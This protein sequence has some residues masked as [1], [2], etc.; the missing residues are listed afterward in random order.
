MAVTMK[1][2]LPEVYRR[3][4]GTYASIFRVEEY[5]LSMD[6]T[7]LHPRRENPS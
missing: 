6:C 3:F 2:V 7:A 1:N 4:R 5:S